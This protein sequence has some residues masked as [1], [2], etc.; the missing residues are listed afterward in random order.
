MT[1]T[2]E[3]AMELAAGGIATDFATDVFNMHVSPFAGKATYIVQGSF[4]DRDGISDFTAL[5]SDDGELDFT[6]IHNR[7]DSPFDW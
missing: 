6:E 5:V 4:E 2:P 7:A 3:Q 1:T